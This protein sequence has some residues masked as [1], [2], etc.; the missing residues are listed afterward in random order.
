MSQDQSLQRSLKE[1]AD[2]KF[3][4]DQ[5]A[6]IAIT[7]IQG[8][9][10]YVNDAFCKIS[11]YNRDELIGQNHRIINSGYHQQ[12]FF[13]ELWSTIT[14]GKVWKGEI[15]NRAKD[16]SCYWV[17]TTIVPFL[18]DNGKPYQFIAIRYEITDRKRVEQEI[19]TLNRELEARILE[20]T[21]DLGEANQQL[22]LTLAELQEREKERHT[23][24]SALTHD[25]RTPLI[26]Q[27]RALDWFEGQSSELPPKLG[28]MIQLF[29]NSNED[30]LKMV[31]QLLET[32]QYE[33]GKIP[34]ITEPLDLPSLIGQC[35]E[36]LDSLA[37][38]KGLELLNQVP[39]QLPTIPA[40]RDQI[41][42]VFMNLL[43]NALSYVPSGGWIKIE[44]RLS[45]HNVEVDISDNGPGIEPE[46]LPHLFE[47]YYLWDKKQRKIGS[48]LGLYICHM[49][50][51]SHR[52][53]IQ[54]EN[55]SDQG[56]LFRLKLPLEDFL[57]ELHKA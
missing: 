15:R 37:A 35:C 7:D 9:I 20:R 19:R 33:S 10:T 44:A 56:C 46:I 40:D 1:L 23:F 18:G 42:R 30:L 49:I 55:L 57:D 53:S 17:A 29:Q 8:N 11:Q 54:A 39:T 51:T 21:A 36:E 4:L 13:I 41:K 43:G 25:L 47:R 22:T 5:S 6:I 31:N 16:G 12:S 50:L 27:K 52:G 34:L 26:A 28:K 45:G 14:S 32:Y 24:V 2:I 38:K 3:A 48:G